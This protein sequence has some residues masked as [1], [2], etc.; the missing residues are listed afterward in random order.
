ME[1]CLFC[2]S[3]IEYLN[4]GGYSKVN[5]P[6]CGDY[7][8][9]SSAYA[10]IKANQ[11]SDRQLSNICS[12]LRE[13]PDFFIN[14][15]NL[16]SLLN[17]TTPSF[18]ERSDRFLLGLE[19]QTKYAGHILDFQVFWLSMAWALN[20]DEFKETIRYLKNMDYINDAASTSDT[21]RF[22]IDPNGWAHLDT[23]KKLNQQSQQG[24][25]AMWFDESMRLVYDTS[26]SVGILNAGYKPHRVDLRQHNDKID[27]E[28]IAQIRSSRFVLADFTDQRGGVYYEAGF[29]KGLGLEVIWSCREDEIDKLHFD[30]RQYNCITWSPDKLDEFSDKIRNRIEA[31][32]GHGSYQ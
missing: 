25:V 24:F 31:V 17:N 6:Q 16:K 22:K 7:K 2:D 27:D 3:Q 8:V 12:W 26:I 5:C 21:I 29:A 9:T 15:G 14:S 18:H 13:N 4:L 23:L 1:P 10:V 11:Y 28:I 30:I 19:K 32:L 20:Y